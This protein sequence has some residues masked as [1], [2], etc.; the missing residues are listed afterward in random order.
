[1]N[2]SSF[3]EVSATFVDACIG[4]PE[5][6]ETDEFV[7]AGTRDHIRYALEI[8]DGIFEKD[9]AASWANLPLHS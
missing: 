2:M 4:R 6:A 1:M 9:L 7:V 8:N 3:F 5:L